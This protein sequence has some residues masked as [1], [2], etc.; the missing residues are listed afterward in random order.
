MD[1]SIVEQNRI[2]E[3]RVGSFLYGTNRPDSDI[4]LSGVFIPPI[5]YYFGLDKVEEV[6]LSV[7]SKLPNGRNAPDAIDRKFYEF[8]KFVTLALENNPNVLSHLFVDEKNIIFINDLGR[9]LL[10]RKQMFLH[11]G[12]KHRFIGYSISQ[13]KKLYV[14]RDNYKDLEKALDVILQYKRTDY[15]R[16]GVFVFEIEKE[17]IESGVFSDNGNQH[18]KCADIYI[19]KNITIKNAIEQI[20]NRV[21]KFGGRKEMVDEYGF[22]VKFAGNLVRLLLEGKELLE[23]GN[24][25]YPLK[26]R[27]LI[28]DIHKGKYSLAE[29]EE[30][31][32]DIENDINSLHETTFLPAKPRYDEVNQFLTNSLRE[33]FRS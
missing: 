27:Q 24:L 10:N 26:E 16:G 14:K 15:Y 17:L 5:N 25:I 7:V 4:D 8:R 13:K 32:T 20:Q 2:L 31:S 28:L 1:N 3:L 30:M 9:E 6:D 21:N 29:I 33:Y 22:D 19:Q 11:K 12:L 18:L 23:T